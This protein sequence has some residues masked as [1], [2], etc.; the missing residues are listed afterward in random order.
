MLIKDRF[1]Q[2]TGIIEYLRDMNSEKLGIPPSKI[3]Q[4]L[5]DLPER[6]KPSELYTL[7][8]DKNHDA[9]KR[10]SSAQNI[11]E[12][13]LIRPIMLYGI[14]ECYRAKQCKEILDKGLINEFGALMNISHNGDR[15]AYYDD[16]GACHEYDWSLPDS[17]LEQ[18]I[19]DLKS[20]NPEHVLRAQIENQSGGYGCSTPEIDYMVDVANE[21]PGVVGAQISGAGLGGCIMVLVKDEAVEDL[22]T[23]LE[24]VYYVLRGLKSDITPCVPVKGS[25]VLEVRLFP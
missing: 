14:S 25:G 13:Y 7:I 1:P 20:E 21:V 9:I 23:R 19:E 12:Y 4:M 2:Y 6:I 18:L 10:I 16:K 24:K 22:V 15:V 8:S 3:Y 5:L 11:P 17:K